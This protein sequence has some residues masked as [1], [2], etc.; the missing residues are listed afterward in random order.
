MEELRVVLFDL[1][2]VVF[3]TE[4]QYTEFWRCECMRY[5]P[6]IPN[7]EQK[8][9]GQTLVE[10]YDKYFGHVRSEQPQI[11]QRLNKFETQ[12]H[13]DYLPGVVEFV[14]DLRGHGVRTAVVTSSNRPKMENVYR[15]HADVAD[16]FDHVFTSEDFTNGKPDPE[17][18]LLGAEYFGVSPKACVGLEDSFNGL[19]SVRS[20]GMFVVGL[21]TTNPRE[22]I[23]PYSDIVWSDYTN[24]GYEDLNHA[25]LQGKQ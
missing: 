17:C 22:T 25:F 24:K 8:I 4:P 14:A 16:L 3:D 9:K 23:L 2:G 13:F 20:A 5:Q 15:Q 21:A 10:I 1:D 19:R 12:M 7:L 18:Y 6:D 11:T